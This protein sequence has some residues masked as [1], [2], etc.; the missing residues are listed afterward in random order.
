LGSAARWA[1]PVAISGALLAVALLDREIGV[2]RWWGLAHD[3]AEAEGRIEALRG[4]IRTLEIERVE[5]GD[6][7][8]AIE[9]AIRAELE[10]A[11]PGE[12]VVRAAPTG[13]SLAL[14][15]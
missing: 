12:T 11:L 1:I 14:V 4:E 9:R 2:A 3:L 15:P 5:L 7:A 10:L 13:S 8:F 6:D